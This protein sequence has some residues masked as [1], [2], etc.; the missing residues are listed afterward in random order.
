M[1]A[2]LF[3]ISPHLGFDHILPIVHGGTDELE[4]LQLL[5][6]H[7]NQIKGILPQES[8]LARLRELGFNEV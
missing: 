2:A 5:C 6:S 1:G 8:L 7:C 4:N 3:S